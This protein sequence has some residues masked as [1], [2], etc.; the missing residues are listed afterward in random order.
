M[1][2]IV[3]RDVEVDGEGVVALVA[4][5]SGR[6]RRRPEKRGQGGPTK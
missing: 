3:V 5:R 6:H 1:G 4:G 2:N